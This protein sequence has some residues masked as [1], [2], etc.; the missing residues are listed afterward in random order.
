MSI[1][2][3]VDLFY[4]GRHVEVSLPVLVDRR[5][6]ELLVGALPRGS[7][8]PQDPLCVFLPG[9]L[10]P[11]SGQDLRFRLLHAVERC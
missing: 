1:R 5:D 7:Q 8:A 2:S 9:S 11:T 10:Q 4:A 3:R 6:L